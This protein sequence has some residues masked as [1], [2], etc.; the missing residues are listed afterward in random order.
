LVACGGSALFLLGLFFCESTNFFALFVQFVA[1]LA[2]LKQG[3]DQNKENGGEQE[4]KYGYGHIRFHC[5][6]SQ[7]NTDCGAEKAAHERYKFNEICFLFRHNDLRSAVFT[8]G[9]F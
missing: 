3:L 9:I 2:D 5:F 8:A 1:E 6:Q 4:E 7:T